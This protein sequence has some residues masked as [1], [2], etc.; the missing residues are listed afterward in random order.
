MLTALG[1]IALGLAFLVGAILLVASRRP[2]TF[3]A[4]R[5]KR[6][7]APPERL[8]PLIDDLRQMNTWNPYALRE[9]SGTSH[10][11]G[12]DRGVGATFEFAGKKSGTGDIAITE[13]V[14]DSKVVLRL[15]MFKP[16]K[17]DNRVEFTLVPVRAETDVTWSMS[18]RQPLI[19]KCMAMIIDCDKMIGRDFE[20]GLANLKAKAESA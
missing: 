4:A 1:Y 12:P 11:R 10:Y 13:S 20:E 19:A 5:T 18:G 17:A 3:H 9:T 14:P 8:F 16:F 7:A 6:I 2:D 15:R